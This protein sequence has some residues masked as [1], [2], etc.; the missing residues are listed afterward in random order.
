MPSFSEEPLNGKKVFRSAPIPSHQRPFRETVECRMDDIL[1]ELHQANAPLTDV[2]NYLDTV[3]GCLKGLKE[4]ST[5]R[6]STGSDVP[7]KGKVPPRVCVSHGLSIFFNHS[8]WFV[9]YIRLCWN[10]LMSF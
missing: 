2:T 3:E 1:R 8:T 9:T 6:T 10:S 4:L 5:C 7:K